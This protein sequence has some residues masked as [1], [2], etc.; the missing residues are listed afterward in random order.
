MIALF[1]TV[2]EPF[3][4]SAVLIELAM[5]FFVLAPAVRLMFT[6]VPFTSRLRLLLLLLTFTTLLLYPSWSR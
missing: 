4:P 6:A 2:A 1:T 5:S 3:T